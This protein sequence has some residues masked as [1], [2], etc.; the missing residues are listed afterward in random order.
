MGKPTEFSVR[1]EVRGS[2]CWVILTGELDIAAAPGFRDWLRLFLAEEEQLR[3]DLTGLD[4][5][6]STGMAVLI[7]A[8]L[9]LRQRGLKPQLRVSGRPRRLFQMMRLEKLFDLHA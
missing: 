9:R 6:D 4:F 2:E 8:A 7:G 3:V 1:T 5:L